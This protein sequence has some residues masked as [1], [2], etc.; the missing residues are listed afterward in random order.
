MKCKLWK[1]NEYWV[2][3]GVCLCLRTPWNDVPDYVEAWNCSNASVF[4]VGVHTQ[5]PRLI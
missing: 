4:T 1:L 2:D 3:I 5:D